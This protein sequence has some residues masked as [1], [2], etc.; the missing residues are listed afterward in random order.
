MIH[1][2]IFE[3]FLKYGRIFKICQS[4]EFYKKYIVF[5]KYA[6]YF[7]RHKPFDIRLPLWRI[8]N[9]KKTLCAHS[10]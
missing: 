8:Q 7:K 9:E 2:E 4:F 1:I 6:P 10:V 3:M 5:M